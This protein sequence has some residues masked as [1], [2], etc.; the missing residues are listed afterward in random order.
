MATTRL[1][2]RLPD[3]DKQAQ[4]VAERLT[5]NLGLSE[6]LRFSGSSE[7]HY[8][9]LAD[10]EFAMEE[11]NQVLLSVRGRGRT[12]LCIETRE[13]AVPV[14]GMP[15]NLAAFRGANYPPYEYPRVP[16]EFLYKVWSEVFA[17]TPFVFAEPS[18]IP[19]MVLGP[20]KEFLT[21]R[22]RWVADNPEFKSLG[23]A[24]LP[25][26]NNPYLPFA[27]HTYTSGLRIH[28]SKTFAINFNNVFGGPTT[29]VNGWILPGIHKFAG[30]DSNGNFRCDRGS[31][32]TP[33]DFSAQLS[34]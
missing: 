7:T 18:V 16:V 10:V 4:E 32:A 29:P 26:A 12:I 20:L 31:F 24:S 6:N 17:G 3:P 15:S 8:P 27:V 25:Q 34:M 33:P 9:L 21:V 19:K 5:A 11:L 28:Y 2:P 23:A 13:G 22:F 14:V 30:M 1:P